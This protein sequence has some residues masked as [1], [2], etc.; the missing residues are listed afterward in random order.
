M[1]ATLAAVY[2][3]VM[4]AKCALP[5]ALSLLIDPRTGLSFRHSTQGGTTVLDP[6]QAFSALFFRS[7]LAVAAGK[8]LL[9]P[10]IDKFGGIRSLQVAL[11]TLASNL[12]FI[13]TCRSYRSF[14]A[15]WIAVDFVFSCCWAACIHAIHECFPP[16]QWARQ[17][18]RVAAAS[19]LG[20]ALAFSAFASILQACSR[21]RVAQPWRPLFALSGCLQIVPVLMLT[22]FGR[23]YSTVR[24]VKKDECSVSV[25]SERMNRHPLRILGREVRRIDFWL[26][27][28]SRSVLMVFASFLLFVPTL[29][30]QV[31]GATPALSARVGSLYAI[32][33]LV[34]VTLGSD[35]FGRLRSPPAKA[36]ALSAL[37]GAST[38]ASA[39]QW[40]HV[41]G[42]WTLG[43]A[44][45]SAS[46]LLWGLS[47]AIPFYLPP[48][49]Y[50]LERGGV[51]SS[52]TIADA[53][54]VAGFAL[55]AAFNGYVAGIQHGVRSAWGP[56]FAMTTACAVVSLLSLT[57]AALREPSPQTSAA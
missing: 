40:G 39:L 30:N 32:G 14:A 5:A 17:I 4:G 23:R 36:L 25:R 49:L 24:N 51:E 43:V 48:S 20:N 53:F 3:A 15:S 55:L 57:A 16:E 19:R 31:Y 28:A 34:A 12:I 8:L 42:W 11:L 13:S 37:L 47:F 45:S 22:A 26:H 44:S 56:T 2:F 35:R 27:L 46:M 54:D 21:R 50:A 29:M 41:G 38:L 6:Q 9:G 1:S 7:T 10:I 33:C 18:S 52:A